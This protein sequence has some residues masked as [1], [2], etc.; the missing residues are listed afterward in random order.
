MLSGSIKTYSDGIIFLLAIKVPSANIF[1][2]QN[3]CCTWQIM[4][5]ICTSLG[6]TCSSNIWRDFPSFPFYL[7]L[8]CSLYIHDLALKDLQLSKPT[9]VA[10]HNRNQSW[11]IWGKKVNTQELRLSYRWL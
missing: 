5:P 11:H 4:A 1:Y 3:L 7:N 2:F 10:W 9:M 8:L 6:K